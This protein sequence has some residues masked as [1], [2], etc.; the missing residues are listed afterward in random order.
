MYQ[1]NSNK[2]K[3]SWKVI[4]NIIKANS[5]FNKSNM[6]PDEFN[7]LF[8]NSIKKLQQNSGLFMKNKSTFHAIDGLVRD[9]LRTFEF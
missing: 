2:C 6:A 5:N 1:H 7:N 4:N 9:V 3:A 8:K